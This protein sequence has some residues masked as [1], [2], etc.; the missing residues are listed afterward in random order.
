MSIPIS[1]GAS[2]DLRPKAGNVDLDR[3]RILV[4]PDS[5]KG[6]LSAP[7]A[8]L[9]MG[10]GIRRALPGASVRV[11]PVSD[12][13]E[14]FIDALL[15]AMRGTIMRA[16]VHGPLP[17][18]RVRSRWALVSKGETAVIETASAAGLSLVPPGRRDPCVATTFGVG[19][20]MRSALEKSVSGMLIGL[21]GSATNDGGAGMASALG[22]EFLDANGVRLAPGGASLAK[23]AHIDAGRIDPR[24]AKTKITAACDVTNPLSGPGGASRVFGPQKGG[25]P[26]AV[27]RLEEAL[28]RFAEI[29]RAD[30]GIDIETVPGS[31]A[32]GGL[33]GGL[34]AFCG[35]RIASGIDI[36]LEATGFDGAL[37]ASDLVVTGEGKIDSQTRS[38]KA[39]SGILRH[40]RA[41]RVPVAAVAGTIEGPRES[42][43]G[44]D[45]FA[46][47]CSLDDGMSAPGESPES[48]PRALEE[49]TRTLMLTL[50]VR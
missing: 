43:R 34:M 18:Q 10:K 25:D 2:L 8:A 12:G 38:G 40:A 5:F 3:A 36:V 1:S 35:A 21:G 33:A 32:A 11:F 47:L 14:G 39:L 7:E 24:I 27:E 17:E 19:E 13:G 48:A 42:F 28:R 49:R 31:G 23:L 22:V 29:L 50:N 6:T 37:S 9:A 4:A 44:E 41:A 46:A 20:L 15:P 45:G 30:L 26:A 16:E